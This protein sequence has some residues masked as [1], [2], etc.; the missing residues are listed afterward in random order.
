MQ[1]VA[2]ILNGMVIK[3]LQSLRYLLRGCLS[4]GGVHLQHMAQAWGQFGPSAATLPHSPAMPDPSHIYDLHHS[5]Q[6]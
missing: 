4:G 6:Q 1:L 2:T 3:C 5:S